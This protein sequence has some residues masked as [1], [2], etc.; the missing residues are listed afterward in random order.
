MI[1]PKIGA[2]SGLHKPNNLEPELPA[3]S[4]AAGVLVDNNTLASFRGPQGIRPIALG[5]VRPS[6]D[7]GL[8]KIQPWAE[9]VRLLRNIRVPP[10]GKLLVVPRDACWS[11]YVRG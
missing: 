2:R 9:L 5:V 10:P 1:L 7:R 11:L 6:G 4:R 8:D 3:F